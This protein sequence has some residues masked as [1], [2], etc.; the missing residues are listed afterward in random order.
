MVWGAGRMD[1]REFGFFSGEGEFL[2][3]VGGT[4]ACVCP[5][6]ARGAVFSTW[7]CDDGLLGGVFGGYYVCG[8]LL[9]SFCW[10]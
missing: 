10:V 5:F 2:P 8:V 9:M 4:F 3:C 1:G 7:F 6:S